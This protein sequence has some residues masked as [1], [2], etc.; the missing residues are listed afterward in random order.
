MR[1]P[2]ATRAHHVLD[3]FLPVSWQSK[4]EGALNCRLYTHLLCH[5]GTVM[6]V[7]HLERA[8]FVLSAEDCTNAN[9][10]L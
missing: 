4:T 3:R 1:L 10:A 6:M 2:H 9:S 5:H 7:F 8:P